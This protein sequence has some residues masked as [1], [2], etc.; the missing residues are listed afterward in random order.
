MT[1][2]HYFCQKSAF[3]PTLK[4]FECSIKCSFCF[5]ACFSHRQHTVYWSVSF[6]SA[7]YPCRHQWQS[8]GM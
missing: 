2:W 8:W 1:V 7:D 4:R 6:L 3:H 5:A